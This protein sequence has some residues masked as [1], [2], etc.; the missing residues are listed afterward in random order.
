MKVASTFMK[1]FLLFSG[2]RHYLALIRCTK[3]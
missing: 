3:K 2:L 1:Q